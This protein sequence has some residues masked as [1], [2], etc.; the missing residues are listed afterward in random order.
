MIEIGTIDTTTGIK[1]IACNAELPQIP[2]ELIARASSKAKT[3]HGIADPSEKII[4]FFKLTKKSLS[5]NRVLKL[6][7]PTQG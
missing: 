7:N 5:E 3:I 6:F 2:L 1:K 4:V